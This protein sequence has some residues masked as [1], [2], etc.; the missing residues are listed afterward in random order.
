MSAT[1][2]FAIILMVMGLLA[3]CGGGVYVAVTPCGPLK[4]IHAK[5]AFSIYQQHIE[6]VEGNLQSSIP[7]PSYLIAQLKSDLRELQ[8]KN[9]PGCFRSVANPL[10]C[11]INNLLVYADHWSQEGGNPVPDQARKK[12]QACM[13]DYFTELSNLK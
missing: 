11:S 3:I 5:N 2:I 8:T 10:E 13:V 4:A 1:K 12:Y 7:V 6:A 9:L